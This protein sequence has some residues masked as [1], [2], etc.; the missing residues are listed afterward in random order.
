MYQGVLNLSLD[1]KY[2]DIPNKLM[3]SSDYP[4]IIRDLEVLGY[5]SIFGYLFDQ[6]QINEMEQIN[7]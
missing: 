7:L 4:D 6:V 3:F 5:Y 2:P 1:E